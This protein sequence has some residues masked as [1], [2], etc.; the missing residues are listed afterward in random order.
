M[1]EQRALLQESVLAA[2]VMNNY[3][4]GKLY[5]CISQ[6]DSAGTVHAGVVKTLPG[7]NY[8]EGHD[9]RVLNFLKGS[10]YKALVVDYTYGTSSL[11]GIFDPAANGVW[12]TPVVRTNTN[13]DINNPYSIVTNGNDM[14]LMGYDGVD[15]I[16]VDLTTFNA[17]SGN[18]FFTYTPLAGKQGHGVD[19]DAVEIDGTLYLAALFINAEGYSNYGNSQLVLVDAATGDLF[20]T[21]D[22]NANANSI[23]IAADKFAY[24]TSFG[25]V[26]QPG[27]NATSQ[28]E[29]VDL[30]IPEVTQTIGMVT[31]VTDGD[32]V[33]IALV[34]AN[35]YV[36]TANFDA[37]YQ[38][39][40]YRLV[41]TTQAFLK[42]GSFG[43]VPDVDYSTYTQNLIPSGATWLLA[44]DGIVLWFVRATEIYTID[45]SV[46]VSSAALTKRA[47]A[48]LYNATTNPQGL[49]IDDPHEVYGQLN[50][51][52]VVIPAASAAPRAF[53][54][55][56]SHTKHAK[57]MLPPEELEKFKAAAV[58][59]AAAQEKK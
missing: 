45:T 41:K 25:G 2:G 17:A 8:F 40:T 30:S 54:R 29:V 12:G 1:S 33:D 19:M 53:A 35:A 7:G 46:N 50:T 14:F 6:V 59:A 36:L 32:Y 5:G 16:K 27:G 37:N 24:V 49:G 58:Q 22:L 31:P 15:I 55:G 48:T 43:T 39:Y 42:G 51:A 9:A 18:P 34:G 47:D 3:T 13:W 52:A 56:A 4:S 20:E 26:Q 10:E 57:V 38:F 21:I 11:Y 44:Y 28:L 23:A